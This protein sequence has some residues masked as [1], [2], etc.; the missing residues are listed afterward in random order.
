VHARWK[1]AVARGTPTLLVQATEMS[2]PTLERLGFERLG[3]MRNMVDQ[4]ELPAAR[5]GSG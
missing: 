5:P 4:L 2:R 1:D 3:E